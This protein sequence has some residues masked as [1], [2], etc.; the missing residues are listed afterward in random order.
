MRREFIRTR[1]LGSGKGEQARISAW[2][3]SLEASLRQRPSK[4]DLRRMFAEAA[5]NTAE[6]KVDAK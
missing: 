6:M 3:R 2:R 1:T 4:D 5:R